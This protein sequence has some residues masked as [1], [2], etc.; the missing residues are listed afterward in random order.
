LAK[1]HGC[2]WTCLVDW[3]SFQYGCFWVGGLLTWQHVPQ[4]VSELAAKVAELY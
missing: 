2:M 3:A 1:V 4:K